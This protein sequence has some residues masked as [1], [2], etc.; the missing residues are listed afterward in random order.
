MREPQESG[1]RPG[2]RP[3]TGYI[4]GDPVVRVEAP[5][6]VETGGILRAR[7]A[8]DPI[9]NGFRRSYA[10]RSSSAARKNT[11]ACQWPP[12]VICW[13]WRSGPLFHD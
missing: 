11:G 6:C 1:C 8:A 7:G 3:D 10:R 4:G 12:P 5:A 9:V 13:Q 2:I